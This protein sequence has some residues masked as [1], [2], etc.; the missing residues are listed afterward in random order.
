MHRLSAPSFNIPQ[1]QRDPRYTLRL[2]IT[3]AALGL[4]D[5]SQNPLVGGGKRQPHESLRCTIGAGLTT[6]PYWCL[7]DRDQLD[8]AEA[9]PHSR[10]ELA[11]VS[12][13]PTGLKAKHAGIY[14]SDRAMLGLGL[15][16]LSSVFLATML[17]C[18]KTLKQHG[19]PVWQNLLARSLSIMT[20][21]VIA[22][23]RQRVNPF[24]NR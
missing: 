21:S 10:A 14:H 23:A 1:H 2:H 9:Q 18:A 16:A 19:F 12:S 6:S 8:A 4:F 5:G 17:I 7:Q 3:A 24:G 22:C 15:Y 13:N 20:F 11:A